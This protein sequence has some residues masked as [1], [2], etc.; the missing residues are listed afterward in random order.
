M[1]M[2]KYTWILGLTLGLLLAFGLTVYAQSN[3]V[4][5]SITTTYYVTAKTLPLGAGIVHFAYE[6]IGSNVSDTGEGLFH[7]ATV[8]TLGALTLEK[9]LYKDEVGKGVFY[10]ENG[11]KVF[12]AYHY[13]GEMKPKGVAMGKGGGTFTGGTGKCAGIKGGFESTRYSLHPAVEGTAQTYNKMKFR[14]TLP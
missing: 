12:F 2:K 11:D 13:S 14:Y 4:T 1:T 8:R 9:T 10:L 6:A 3:E 7:N 5:E